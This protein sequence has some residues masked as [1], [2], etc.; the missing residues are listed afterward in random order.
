MWFDQIRLTVTKQPAKCHQIL[1]LRPVEEHRET[2]EKKKSLMV[3]Y[4]VTI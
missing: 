2:E 1:H 3:S 4:T